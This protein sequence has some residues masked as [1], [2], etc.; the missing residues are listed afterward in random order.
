MVLQMARP[1][2]DPTSGIYY[3]RVRLPRSAPNSVKGRKAMLPLNREHVHVTIGDITKL[4]LRTRDPA[5]A[6]ARHVEAHAAF[7]AHLEASKSGPIRLTMRQI[8]AIAGTVY[9]ELIEKIGDD[10]GEPKVWLHVLRLHGQATAAGKQEEWY[11]PLID[12]ELGK[13][14]LNVD[15]WSRETLLK[16]VEEVLIHQAQVL[17]RRSEGDFTPDADAARY[18]DAASALAP[19]KEQA[20]QSAPKTV[21]HGTDAEFR[22]LWNKYKETVTIAPSTTRR[23][24]PAVDAFLDYLNG[25]PLS[26]VTA[27]D[28]MLFTDQRRAKGISARSVNAVDLA[29]VKRVFSFAYSRGLIGSNPFAGLRRERI[30]DADGAGERDTKGFRPDE[31][32]AILSAALDIE[33]TPGRRGAVLV[34]AFK[35]VPW[36]LAYSGARPGEIIQLRKEDF[37]CEEG[38]NY[39]S[40]CDSAGT[41][42][43]G[44]ARR[45]PLH[46]HLVE[47]GLLT[48]VEQT[49]GGYLFINATTSDD[50]EELLKA[51]DVTRGRLSNWVRQIGVKDPH[52]SPSHAWRHTF[53]TL[54]EEASIPERVYGAICG[55]TET[56]M[57]RKYGTVTLAAKAAAMGKFP[58]YDLKHRA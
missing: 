45:V 57:S 1:W 8:S 49:K 56:A 29:A 3:L 21:T 6:R 39:I 25:R 31:W 50:E 2:R 43:T 9:H 48:F 38:I 55:W 4:S 35:W 23:W 18:P 41:I 47:L 54:A 15:A 19:L 36:M 53:N 34:R 33:K 42:K 27:A 52:I 17:L 22:E 51:I 30:K 12:T 20:S 7:I 58:R 44:Q 10:P 26:T 46:A 24:E 28:A 13:L 11:G 40:I 32:R 5:E 14:A 37:G 16:S